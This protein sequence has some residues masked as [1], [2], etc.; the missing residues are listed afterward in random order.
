MRKSGEQRF[1]HAIVYP[2]LL[3]NVSSI[4]S[5]RPD[6]CDNA[7]L[8]PER[9][10]IEQADCL[11]HVFVA[12]A[13]LPAVALCNAKNPLSSTYRLHKNVLEEFDFPP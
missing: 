4:E 6:S 7:A 9:V 12:F 11:P 1:R 10:V 13:I 8:F 2:R 3:F 5:D